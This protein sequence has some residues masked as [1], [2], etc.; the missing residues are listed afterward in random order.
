[1]LPFFI[2]SFLTLSFLMLLHLLFHFAINSP[3]SIFFKTDKRRRNECRRESEL[4]K[5]QDVWFCATAVHISTPYDR[6]FVVMAPR[7]RYPYLS[8]SLHIAMFSFPF[9]SI[10]PLSS[11]LCSYFANFIPDSI[12]LRFATSGCARIRLGTLK[13]ARNFSKSSSQG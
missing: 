1:M 3:F 9:L 12:I 6:L 5:S 13:P 4:S 10:P 8:P 7:T 11:P 2:L